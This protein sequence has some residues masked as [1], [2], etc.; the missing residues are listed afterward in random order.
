MKKKLDNRKM[1]NCKVRMII[2]FGEYKRLDFMYYVFNI[3]TDDALGNSC[4]PGR[5]CLM[6]E[7][8]NRK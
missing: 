2:N 5:N 6:A 4:R 1:E 3:Y 7:W 8:V